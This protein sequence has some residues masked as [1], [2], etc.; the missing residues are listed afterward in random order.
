[1][2]ST[3]E[4]TQ[5]QIKWCKVRVLRPKSK[6]S[7][8]PI[9]ILPF[10]KASRLDWN[11]AEVT[12]MYRKAPAGSSDKHARQLREMFRVFQ[13]TKTH[14]SAEEADLSKSDPGSSSASASSGVVKVRTRPSPVSPSLSTSESQP[15][16]STRKSE[17]R[18]VEGVSVVWINSSKLQD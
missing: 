1:M 7:V 17:N 4:P 11:S 16:R 18:P 14:K 6:Q 15:S 9:L 5:G 10:P 2:Y 13:R 8:C 3:L 12:R